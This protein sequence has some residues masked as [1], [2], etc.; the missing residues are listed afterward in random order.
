[1]RHMINRILSAYSGQGRFWLILGI[2]A[3]IV[4]A[5]ISYQYGK[6]LTILHGLGFALVAVFFALLPD[7]AYSEIENRRIASGL[8]MGALC[9]PLG[10]V[11]FY[12]HLGY[13]AGVRMGDMQQTGVQNV[14]FD[15]AREKVADNK[16]N[17]KLWTTQLDELRAASPWVATVNA[18]GLRA[19]L[20]PMDKSI[21]IETRR[22]GCGPK[23][24]KL[25][26]AKADI[27]DRI[28]KAEQ[29]AN[30]EKQIAATQKLVDNYREASANTE[31]RSSAVVNQ[32]NV[33]AQ[34]FLA[35]TGAEP[36]K[37]IKPDEVTS[38][39]T[40]IFI[41]GGGSLAFM[42]MA[43]VGFFL[44][45]RNRHREAPM[46]ALPE[47]VRPEPPAWPAA[48]TE[49]R[50][51]NPVHEQLEALKAQL[52]SLAGGVKDVRLNVVQSGVR[53]TYEA[54]CAQRGLA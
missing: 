54:L 18:D 25:M 51:L 4:D 39:F 52:A 13:G 9:I 20:A 3:L 19:Q 27:E 37:A 21:E 10:T 23:C 50:S 22:G 35:M 46:S 17:L 44:A 12:S 47:I 1:M 40:S 26:A 16:R 43:P 42:I 6:S 41:A 2:V 14:R 8:A 32:N 28:G 38:S 45:G 24:Q 5:A 30:L 7:A 29:R 49:T 15:D 48:A 31:Y 53:P 11:A 36:D 34:L 33:A